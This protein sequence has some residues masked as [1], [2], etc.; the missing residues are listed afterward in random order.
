[1][2]CKVCDE[3]TVKV[4]EVQ[5]SIKEP[6]GSKEY[7][8]SIAEKCSNCGVDVDASPDKNIM[9][10]HKRSQNT[11]VVNMIRD[12]KKIFKDDENL[13]NVERALGLRPFAIINTWLDNPEKVTCSEY[14]LL[15]IILLQPD[16]VYMVDNLERSCD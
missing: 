12:I 5:S 16:I 7:F 14:A 10:A 3:D 9:E 11:A 8:T 15:E 2:Q 1:M 4:E 13:I 6:F